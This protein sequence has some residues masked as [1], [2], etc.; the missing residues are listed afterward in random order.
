MMHNYA[1]CT[2]AAREVKIMSPELHQICAIM[3]TYIH[4]V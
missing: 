3:C 4:L 2:K 1:H